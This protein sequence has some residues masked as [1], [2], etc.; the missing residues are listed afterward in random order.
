VP[1]NKPKRT[2]M[3]QSQIFDHFVSKT[4]LDRKQVAAL[5]DELASL[6]QTEVLAGRE[7]VLPGFGKLVLAQRQARQGRNP[8][9]GEP[10]KIPAKQSIKFRVANS[11]K[12]SALAGNNTTGSDI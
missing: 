5:F 11:M 9:T 12:T 7:F 6:A 2:R 10:I 4:R 8:S 1:T 3:T